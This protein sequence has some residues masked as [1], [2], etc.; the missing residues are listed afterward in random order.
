MFVCA[1]GGIGC[2]IIIR[3]SFLAGGRSGTKEHQR[4]EALQIALGSLL[5][6]GWF[7]VICFPSLYAFL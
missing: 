1:S 2:R 6:Y 3:R 4:Y 7:D 5:S